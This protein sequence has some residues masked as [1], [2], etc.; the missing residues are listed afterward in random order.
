MDI[1]EA[2]EIIGKT[3]WQGSRLGLERMELLLN[4][5]GNP[6]KE[7]KYIHIAG[8]NGKGSTAAMLASVLNEAGYKTGLFTS[9]YIQYFNERIQINGENIPDAKLIAVVEQLK[10]LIDKMDDKPTEFELITIIAFWYFYQCRCD[11]VVLEVG[12]G[13]R[14]DSTNVIPSPEVAV[15]TAIDLDHTRELGDTIEKI[16]VEKAGII[17]KNCDVVLY[18]QKQSVFKVLEKICHETSARLHLVD[19]S[20]IEVTES[21]MYGQCLNFEGFREIG[22][23][24]L[25]EYQQKNAAVVLKTIEILQNKG[26]D[27]VIK[28]VIGGMKKAKWPGRF[29]VLMRKPYFVID[30]AHNPN[31]VQ[32]LVDNINRYFKDR[33]IIFLIGVLKDKDYEAMIKLI[34][35]YGDRFIIV[36][37][38]NQRA[39][40]KNELAEFLRANSDA[41]VTEACDV[42]DGIKSALKVAMD[43]DTIIAFGS[44]YMV[45]GIRNFFIPQ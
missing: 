10:D 12:L 39:L 13:G 6:E 28:D 14:L 20:H 26:W 11:I 16:A 37:P 33:K 35:P 17:K 2:M 42:N 5:L 36:Q 24:L 41:D 30:G 1:T 19:F 34:M 4:L 7:L 43:D 32:S 31:G 22:I 23:D 8:T 29:E 40:P 27:I 25:G 21:N 3:A 45:G 18:Q 44:L 15:I 38:E 9:P